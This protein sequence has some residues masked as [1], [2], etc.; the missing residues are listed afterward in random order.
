MIHETSKAAVELEG[1]QGVINDILHV[2]P[3]NLGKY[4]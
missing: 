3:E 4:R 1:A 2:A